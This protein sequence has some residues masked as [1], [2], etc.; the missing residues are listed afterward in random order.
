MIIDKIENIDKYSGTPV[1][2]LNFVKAVTKEDF[3]GHYDFCDGVY[4][5][6]DEYETKKF[7]S[8]KFEAHK[9]FIDIQII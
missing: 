4:A 8:C 1:E 9:K 5:N 2:A 6:I 7:D 3:A